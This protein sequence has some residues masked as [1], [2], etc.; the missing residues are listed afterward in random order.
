MG[1]PVPA[2]PPG[3]P[4]APG[5]P[6]GTGGPPT[7]G[8]PGPCRARLLGPPGGPHPH[9]PPVPPLRAVPSP[10]R[11][12]PVPRPCKEGA[13]TWGSPGP[14][15]A[16]CQVAPP[17]CGPGCW[18][19]GDGGRRS[20][21]P[22]PGTTPEERS[23][24]LPGWLGGGGGAPYGRTIRGHGLTIDVTIHPGTGCGD[25]QRPLS[26]TCTGPCRKSVTPLAPGPTTTKGACGSGSPRCR[27]AIREL[28]SWS[29]PK[30]AWLVRWASLTRCDCKA[31]VH[32]GPAHT[33]TS[34]K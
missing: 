14:A 34:A 17:A 13:P 12:H 19:P 16:G 6:A 27:I 10:A 25:S 11:N 29:P 5:P 22:E 26:Q 4:N 28:A 1:E 7:A 31:G 9:R 3:A 21:N 33:A 24:G 18:S 20:T 32:C 23:K 8:P 15:P 2:E 30:V